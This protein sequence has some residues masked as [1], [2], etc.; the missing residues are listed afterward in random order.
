MTKDGTVYLD[1]AGTTP[2]DP[3]V[4]EVMMPYFS[5]LYG[6]PSSIHSVGQEARYALDESRERVSQVLHCRAEV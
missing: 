1:H 5:Q 3:R 2:M 4:L 6:N